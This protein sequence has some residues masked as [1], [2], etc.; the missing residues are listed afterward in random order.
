MKKAKKSRTQVRPAKSFSKKSLLVFVLLFGAVGGYVLFRSFAATD[1]RLATTFT[2]TS[3]YF[4]H[5][6]ANSGFT[7]EVNST[8]LYNSV[9]TAYPQL[10]WVGPGATFTY[11]TN[12]TQTIQACFRVRDIGQYTYGSAAAANVSFAITNNG[13]AEVIKSVTATL[14]S[15]YKD[16]TAYGYYPYCITT[17]T[18]PNGKQFTNLQYRVTVNKGALWV[19]SLDLHGIDFTYV[20]PAPTPTPTPTPSPSPTPTPTP[21]SSSG[22]TPTKSKIIVQGSG[23]S[24]PSG[25][26]KVD[27]SPPTKPTDFTASSNPDDPGVQLNWTASTDDV[28]VAGYKLERSSDDS[29]TW[30]TLTSSLKD[31]NY[32]DYQTKFDTKYEYRVSAIDTTGNVSEAANTQILASSFQPNAGP[33]KSISLHSDDN[34]VGVEIP[35]GSLKTDAVCSVQ[36]DSQ[37]G[38]G[39]SVK[40]YIQIGG[41]YNIICKG[42]DNVVIS[43]FE[44]PL[45]VSVSTKDYKKYKTRAYYVKSTGNNNWSKIAKF[46]HNKKDNTDNFILQNGNSFV[47]MAKLSH[48]PIWIKLLIGLVILVG[49][50]FGFLLITRLITRRRLEQQYNDYYRKS[51]G[52]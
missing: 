29:Q 4:Q 50:G 12:G 23:S 36:L 10:L 25:S 3:S 51:A 44:K 7:Q 47:V 27:T 31:T 30:E 34:T 1:P 19:Q 35:A 18:L 33:D 43:S 45:S 40:N 42:D 48:T 39:P 6:A 16:N 11:Y 46:T 32:F 37:I 22:S 26:I 5:P 8:V 14:S 49:V 24:I 17:N 28:A 52:L 9:N 2:A 20:P 41:P 13:G 21:S 38:T 15:Q